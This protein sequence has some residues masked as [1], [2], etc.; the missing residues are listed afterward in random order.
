MG[1]RRGQRAHG[2]LQGVNLTIMP[3]EFVALTGP[4]GS[5]KTTLLKLMAGLERPNS[6]SVNVA[7]TDLG[8]LAEAAVARLRLQG[9]AM[10]FQQHQLIP[11]LSALENVAL[12][13]LLGGEQRKVAL[14]RGEVMLAEL[15]YTGETQQLP[16]ELSLGE[17][18]RLAIARAL[19]SETPLILADEP[20]ASLDSVAADAVMRALSRWG[21]ERGRAVVLATH[22]ARAAAHADRSCRLQGGALV[23]A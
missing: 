12:P 9:I 1:Y 13:L 3:G 10:V 2:V 15:G 4:S 14:S 11:T 16:A 6:G 8:G 17:R 22:E 5:G 7:G 19:V 23:A 20:T 18:Q 21:S